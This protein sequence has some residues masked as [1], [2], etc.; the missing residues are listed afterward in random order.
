MED[1]TLWVRGDSR[2][3]WNNDSMHVWPISPSETQGQITG[4]RGRLNGRNQC[5]L[6]PVFQIT[7]K[8]RGTIRNFE[9]SVDLDLFRSSQVDHLFCWV[10]LLALSGFWPKSPLL[11]GTLWSLLWAEVYKTGRKSPWEETFNRL[12]QEP[13]CALASDWPQILCHCIFLCPISDQLI[14]PFLLWRLIQS[15]M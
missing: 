5:K 14:S 8:G 11:S 2:V 15:V 7:Y 12:V 10:M 3:I 4:V 1:W 6:R 9:G 13:I